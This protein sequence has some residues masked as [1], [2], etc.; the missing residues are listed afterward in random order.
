MVPKVACHIIFFVSLHQHQ[1][2]N[3][4]FYCPITYEPP[5]IGSREKLFTTFKPLKGYLYVKILSLSLLKDISKLYSLFNPP[6][7]SPYV[8]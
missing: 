6:T 4:C 8:N 2:T 7:C 1:L 3:Q 5:C